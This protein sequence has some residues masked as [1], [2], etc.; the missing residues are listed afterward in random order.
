MPLLLGWEKV[1]VSTLSKLQMEVCG[2][3]L[4]G[5]GKFIMINL[6]D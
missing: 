4:V 2:L 6:T 3:E 5:T 1:A